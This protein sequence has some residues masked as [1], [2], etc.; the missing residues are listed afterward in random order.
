M[1]KGNHRFSNFLS[2]FL[3]HIWKVLSTMLFSLFLVTTLHVMIFYEWRNQDFVRKTYFL[4]FVLE[5]IT[6]KSPLCS[7]P[8]WF[9]L[10]LAGS[11]LPTIVVE[12]ESPWVLPASPVSL[13]WSSLKLSLIFSTHI[14]TAA[15]A[16]LCKHDTNPPILTVEEC[17]PFG[18][19][20]GV[21]AY[22]AL[23]ALPIGK[24]KAEIHVISSASLNLWGSHPPVP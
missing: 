16:V 8:A 23:S 2:P 14:F 6:G 3:F 10:Q 1:Q 17:T 22:S 13:M 18:F 12:T 21:L 19:C 20:K 9:Y 15:S 11:Y 4:L 7:V 24:T 5:V